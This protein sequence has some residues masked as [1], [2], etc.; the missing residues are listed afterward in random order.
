MFSCFFFLVL[1]IEWGK[2]NNGALN[3]GLIVSFPFD[4]LCL[5]DWPPAAVRTASLT[6]FNKFDGPFHSLMVN[7]LREKPVELLFF[8]FFFFPCDQLLFSLFPK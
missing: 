1:E 5:V 3:I 6:T 7:N 2:N 8:P 4:N